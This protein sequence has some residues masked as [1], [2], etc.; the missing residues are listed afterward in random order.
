MEDS[1]KFIILE[2]AAN[3]Q[4]DVIN[5]STSNSF[6]FH[7]IHKVILYSKRY[8]GMLVNEPL[9]RMSI[10]IDP[11]YEG[12]VIQGV[13]TDSPVVIV[14]SLDEV[15]KYAF[16]RQIED[17]YVFGDKNFTDKIRDNVYYGGFVKL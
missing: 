10:V 8:W 5:L 15:I 16:S 12:I 9:N 3:T 4:V 6:D 14:K 13:N 17:I 11:T 7:T 2:H 1:F